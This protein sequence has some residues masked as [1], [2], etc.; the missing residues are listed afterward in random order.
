M[1]SKLTINLVNVEW[2]GKTEIKPFWSGGGIYICNY[3]HSEGQPKM[4]GSRITFSPFV[5]HV[6]FSVLE[7]KEQPV[8]GFVL[9]V[10]EAME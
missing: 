6:H 10:L 1:V 7:L 2:K 5:T 4:W 8:N 9:A 3:M